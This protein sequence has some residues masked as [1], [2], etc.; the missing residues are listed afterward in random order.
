[1]RNVL[2]RVAYPMLKRINKFKNA[3]KNESCY[4]IGDGISVKY[5]DLNKFTD[6]ISIPCGYLPFHNDYDCL[7]VPYATLIE[8]YYFY[9]TTRVFSSR[10]SDAGRILIFNYLQKEYRK[11]IKKYQTTEFFVNLSNYPVL[12]NEN[13][14]YTFRDIPDSSLGNDHISKK[15]NCYA[16]SLRVQILLAIYMGF[17]HV[18]LVGHDYTHSPARSLHWYEKGKGLLTPMPEF[19]KDFLN[20]AKNF[21]DITTITVDSGSDNLD[22]KTYQEHTGASPLF[23]ENTEL[24][25]LHYLKALSTWPVY[26]IF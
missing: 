4:L 16:G 18:Y 19:S 23:R 14:T 8:T 20:Y 15:F 22:F 26:E 6:M 21:I 10:E 25:D 12:F 3:H 13:I 17:D 24:L 5:F 7:H 9:P 1:M 2:K 11:I